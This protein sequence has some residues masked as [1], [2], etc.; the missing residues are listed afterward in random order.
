MYRFS[1]VYFKRFVIYISHPIIDQGS[2]KS[3]AFCPV[4]QAINLYNRRELVTCM[5]CVY[6]QAIICFLNFIYSNDI[7]YA[8]MYLYDS[9]GLQGKVL[10]QI[11][12]VEQRKHQL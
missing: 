5:L 7:T 6:K 2:Y 11:F 9:S 10:E 12:Q 8:Y 1:N 4:I 3:P